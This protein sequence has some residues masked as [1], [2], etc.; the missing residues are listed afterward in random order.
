M[1]IIP[2]TKNLLKTSIVIV[3]IR[4]VANM[5]FSFRME[6]WLKRQIESCMKRHNIKTASKALHRLFHEK[7]ETIKRLQ[8]DI[9]NYKVIL[10]KHNAQV[11]NGKTEDSEKACLFYDV[12]RS[13][14][15]ICRNPSP[16]LKT[17]HLTVKACMTCIKLRNKESEN[18]QQGI[19]RFHEETK[20]RV[21]NLQKRVKRTIE[22][23]E[24]Y[25]QHEGIRVLVKKCEGYCRKFHPYR[26]QACQELKAE[27]PLAY[28]DFG[29]AHS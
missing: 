17:S 8:A 10:T 6:D 3:K 7:D 9:D 18:E 5:V 27:K 20:N 13:G 12:D 23:E 4:H 1:P 22:Q 15:P 11:L 21:H 24:T 2:R 28:S 19:K 26:Y 14:K 29:E 16:P 25:C